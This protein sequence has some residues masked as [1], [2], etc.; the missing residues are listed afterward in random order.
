MTKLGTAFSALADSGAAAKALIEELREHDPRVLVFFAGIKQEGRLL[1]EAISAAFPKACVLGCSSDGE[2]S[3]KGFGKG[4]AAAIAL[5]PQIV[6]RC[7]VEMVD[8]GGDISQAMMEA[9]GRLSSKLGRK[10]RDLDPSQ[11][12]ALALVEG[13][14]GREERINEALGDMAPFLPFVGGSAGDDI[15]FSSTWAFADGKY[16]ADGT[17][18]LVAEM[19]VPFRVL[20]TSS[21][22]PLDAT[23][24][25]TKCDP[26]RRLILELNG[27]PAARHYAKLLGTTR[28][29]LAFSHFVRHPLGLMIDGEPWLRSVLNAVDTALMMACAVVEGAELNLMRTTDIVSD[30]RAALGAA[31]EALGTPVS[32]AI[33]FNCAYRMLEASMDGRE[34]EYHQVLSSIVHA[35]M[36]TNGE[37]YLG[38]INHT[39]TGLLFA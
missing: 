28:E 23:V 6:G 24:C 26:S 21:A 11:Y 15:T 25:V 13:A 37:S 16:L 34:R 29:E 19:L 39:L 36:H 30:T 35:G 8:T 2:F 20:K 33:L 18:L 17:A 27:E 14:K 9:S 32:G 12:A 38:H 3:E 4:G 31:G 10:L 1:G 22:E 5:G 7:A